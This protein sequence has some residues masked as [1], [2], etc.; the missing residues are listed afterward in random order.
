MALGTTAGGGV[1]YNVLPVSTA[2]RK[3]LRPIG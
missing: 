2:T 3:V 1:A